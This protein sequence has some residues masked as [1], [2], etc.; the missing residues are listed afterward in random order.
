[1]QGTSILNSPH[2]PV[3]VMEPQVLMPAQLPRHLQR[4]QQRLQMV[5]MVIIRRVM[6]AMAVMELQLLPL[7]KAVTVD[8]TVLAGTVLLELPVPMTTMVATVATMTRVIMEAS[9]ATQVKDSQQQQVVVHSCSKVHPSQQ[10]QLPLVIKHRLV[11]G[12]SQPMALLTIRNLP[13]HHLQV[14]VHQCLTQHPLILRVL[15]IT[16]AHLTALANQAM[17]LRATM[18]NHS[19]HK[20]HMEPRHM[21]A[22]Q[23]IVR[24]SQLQHQVS[25]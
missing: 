1:M 6:V 21:V 18:V 4:Q 24:V 9:L 17:Q 8:H 20:T 2:T 12:L 3:Q 22:R 25:L 16:A 19:L 11:M 15:A 14:Q 7:L 10:H 13:A 5:T 23:A